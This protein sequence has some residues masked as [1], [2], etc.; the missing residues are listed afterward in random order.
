M[1]TVAL[2]GGDGAGKTS[3]AN[4]LLES[5]GLP[6]KY[7]YMGISTR[8]S[9]HALPTSQLVLYLKRLRYKKSNRDASNLSPADIPADQLEYSDETHSPL[10]N[11]ARFL[12][13]LAE[14]WYRQLICLSYQMRGYVI[15]FDRHFYFDSAPGIIDSPDQKLLFSDRLFFWLMS[16]WYPKP[17]LSI[18]LDAPPEMLYR[19]KGEA[20]VDYLE[21]QRAIF[22]QQGEKLPHFI[23]VDASKPL[24]QVTNEVIQHVLDFFT[25]LYQ[26][27]KM[28]TQHD[29]TET[30]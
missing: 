26:K 21:K 10:W 9:K 7:L 16:H 28:I 8:S 6:M 23:R 24:D 13:R 22:L 30:K 3:I 2:I 5:S 1:F 25:H 12:N 4:A 17:T 20:T 14:A 18:F 15:I 19:R 27:P 11:A 29:E